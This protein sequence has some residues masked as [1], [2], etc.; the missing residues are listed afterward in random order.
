[1]DLQEVRKG[2]RIKTNDSL[3]TTTGMLIGQTYLDARKPAA[4]GVIHDWVPGHGGDVWWIKHDGGEEFAPYVF[5]EFEP[6]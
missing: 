2:L 5:T 1:M 6:A 4:A 3:G